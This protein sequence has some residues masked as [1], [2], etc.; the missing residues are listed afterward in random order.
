LPQAPSSQHITQ[1]ERTSQL[2]MQPPP[3]GAL[4]DITRFITVSSVYWLCNNHHII[5]L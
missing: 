3:K 5:T 4:W 1:P 2:F